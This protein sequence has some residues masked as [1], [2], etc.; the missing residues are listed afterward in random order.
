VFC[1]QLNR[2]AL[3]FKLLARD[4]LLFVKRSLLIVLAIFIED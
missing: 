1:V 2:F 3:A 4:V